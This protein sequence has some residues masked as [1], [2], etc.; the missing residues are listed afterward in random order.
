M[1]GNKQ[2]FRVSFHNQGKIYEVYAER[3]N[4]GGLLGFVQIEGLVFGERSG[5]VVD[6]SE[7]RL[8]DEFADVS[9][10]YIPMHA[11]IR[12]D[13]VTRQG[14]GKIRDA[15]GNNVMAFPHSLY[16]STNDPG[17]SEK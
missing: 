6:P 17:G 15:D 9:C 7:E 1:S 8:R 3:V 13:Q 16:Q 14:S 5:V 12:I 2:L 10:S 4:D 11:V